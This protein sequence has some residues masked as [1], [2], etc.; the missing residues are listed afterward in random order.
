ML[1]GTEENNEPFNDLGGFFKCFMITN[2][3]IAIFERYR[4]MLWHKKAMHIRLTCAEQT[5]TITS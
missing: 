2:C 4:Y 5:G 1:K 3:S